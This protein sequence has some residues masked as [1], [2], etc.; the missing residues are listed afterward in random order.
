MSKK[1]N[2]FLTL[3]KLSKQAYGD[4]KWQ[5]IILVILGFI[6]AFLEGIGINALIPL[7][8]LAIG[9][10]EGGQDII[11]RSIE[12][13]FGFL[14]INFSVGY[15]LGFIVFLF[16][17]RAFANVLFSYIKV[18]I[19][20]SYEK[21]TRENLFNKIL[22][23]SWPHLIKQRIGYL[24]S[25]LM[26]DIPAATIL[27]QEVSGAMMMVTSLAIYLFIA[28]N[29]DLY[30][31]L[32]TLIL[33]GILFLFIKPFF[34][35][36]KVLSNERVAMNKEI[37]HF[38]GENIAG[39]KTVKTMNIIDQVAKRG[40]NYFN[41][42][43]DLVLKLSMIKSISRSLIQPIALIFICLIFGLTYKSPNFNLAALAVIIYLIEKI[44]TYI[45]QLQGAL[46]N[47]NEMLPNLRSVLSYENQA[48]A[49]EEIS[50]ASA[51]FVFNDKLE[52]RNVSFAYDPA[53]NVL[54]DLNFVISKGEMVGII[55]PSGVG[56]TTLVDLILRLF[57]V[58]KG[59]ILLD[60]KNIK[61]IDLTGWRRNIGYVSQD[62]FLIN[63]TISNNI[64]FYD[65]SITEPEIEQAAKMANIY[66][67][68]Q[69][70]PDKFNTVIGERGILLSAGQRQRIVIARVLARKP[71]LLILDE[72][73]SA[74]DN[75]S[76]AKIQKVINNLKGKITVVA[77]AHRLSTV[78]DS[79]RL[80]V[81]QDGRVAE[82][83][84]PKILLKD[85]DSY[86]FKTYNIRK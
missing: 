86:F 41:K 6:A 24:E 71:Q 56:K 33:G 55:G 84:D 32:A 26:I 12:K 81:L 52:F 29:I 59:E 42:L 25:I 30:I 50:K 35:R 10:Q 19:G 72:A 58:S 48:L 47:V 82:Q 67:F 57:E 45:Q 1:E 18:K 44:F 53:R 4:Y 39:M 65:E 22:R 61:E 62:I 2:R 85:K 60:G 27:L 46:N 66:D 8:S 11:S 15:L 54:A 36:I 34:Y 43:R 28:I 9:Q 17:L 73:T 79:N 13:L 51:N 21:N 77:I 20:I 78:M 75:E 63:D 5:I 69:S 7:F 3:I 74:L 31:T 14:N 83:G 23:A 49:N 64:R 70:C 68:I 76:E 38:V 16:V 80:I 40:H 37:M